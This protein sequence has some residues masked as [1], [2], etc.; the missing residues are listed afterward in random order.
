MKAP[1][2]I[3]HLAKHTSKVSRHGQ[4]PPIFQ[5]LHGQRLHIAMHFATPYI[6]AQYKVATAPAVVGS[7]GAILFYGAAKFGHGHHRHI[8]LQRTQ[9][10]PKSHHAVAQVSHVAGKH[11]IVGSLVKVRI[12]A[13]TFGKGRD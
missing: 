4:I 13:C 5:V 1:R 3:R 2:L 7:V 6:V 9:V 8:V 10:V 12:P 11:A